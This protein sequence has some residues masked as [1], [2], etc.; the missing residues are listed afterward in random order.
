MFHETEG[1]MKLKRAKEYLEYARQKATEARLALAIA[2]ADAKR[3]KE[4]Y[5][6]AFAQEERREVA[7]RRADYNHCTK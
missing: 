7:R 2:E 5:E 1:Q 6:E 4:K 3:A